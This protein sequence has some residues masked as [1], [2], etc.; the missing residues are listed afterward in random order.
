MMRL[1]QFHN[2]NEN[3]EKK[4]PKSGAIMTPEVGKNLYV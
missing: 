4:V 1:D 3:E 2:R